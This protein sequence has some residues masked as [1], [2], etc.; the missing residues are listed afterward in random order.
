MISQFT[1]IYNLT[2]GEESFAKRFSKKIMRLEYIEFQL[3]CDISDSDSLKEFPVNMLSSFP[4][5]KVI[6]D[7]QIG[8]IVLTTFL[9]DMDTN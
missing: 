6:K 2:F 9:S 8:Q 4:D 1:K 5:Y 3:R 7:F